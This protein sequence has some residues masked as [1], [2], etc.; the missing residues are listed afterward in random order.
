LSV[1]VSVVVNPDCRELTKLATTLAFRMYSRHFLFLRVAPKPVDANW[2]F[3][4]IILPMALDA[5]TFRSVFN[6]NFVD[7]CISHFYNTLFF[8]I[9][10]DQG[11]DSA[12]SMKHINKFDLGTSRVKPS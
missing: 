6:V 9:E 7:A 8:N 2:R 5:E 11:N 3:L 10:W 12:L 4:F 1:A